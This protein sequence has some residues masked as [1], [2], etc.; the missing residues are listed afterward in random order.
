MTMMQLPVPT[1]KFSHKMLQDAFKVVYPDG[2]LDLA[3]D[4]AGSK[5]RYAVRFFANGKVR[6]YS[7][8]ARDLAGE[9]GLITLH[10]LTRNGQQLFVSH[11]RSE[12]D[13][14]AAV[15]NSEEFQAAVKAEAADWGLTYMP[16]VYEVK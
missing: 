16:E 4:L 6:E 5:R 7:L 2:T 14:I 10:T 13:A 12:L 11:D 1:K 15:G 8:T 3:K 9:L